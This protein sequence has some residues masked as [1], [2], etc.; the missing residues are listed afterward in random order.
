M[1]F[2]DCDD[3]EGYTENY[4]NFYE[5]LRRKHNERL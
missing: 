4:E 5:Y 1:I 3:G 2:T